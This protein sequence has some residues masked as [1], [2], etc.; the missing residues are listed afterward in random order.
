MLFYFQF[1][2][3]PNVI[4]NLY[5]LISFMEH[6]RSWQRSAMNQNNNIEFLVNNVLKRNT[7]NNNFKASYSIHYNFLYLGRRKQ[8]EGECLGE[9]LF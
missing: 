5:D 2:I 6:R 4:S 3:S 9:L 7:H 8:H 1:V